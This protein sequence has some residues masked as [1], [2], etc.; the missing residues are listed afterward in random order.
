MWGCPS[1]D[2]AV[3]LTPPRRPGPVSTLPEIPATCPFRRIR[4]QI[5]KLT[6]CVA[7]CYKVPFGDTHWTLMIFLYLPGGRISRSVPISNLMNGSHS[8]LSLVTYP[9]S[10]LKHFWDQKFF[11]RWHMESDWWYDSNKKKINVCWMLLFRVVKVCL[12]IWSFQIL[13]E[14]SAPCSC[15]KVFPFLSG[16]I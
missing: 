6:M 9:F 8:V 5:L 2:T 13:S 4:T 11:D 1:W 12:C 10:L 14:F 7:A 16:K 15:I 3:S